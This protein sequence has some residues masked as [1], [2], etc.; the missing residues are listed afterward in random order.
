MK[1][2]IPY[3]NHRILALE[4]ERIYTKRVKRFFERL[5]PEEWEQHERFKTQLFEKLI[6]NLEERE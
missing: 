5:T 1:K 3:I 6:K 4:L 2:D